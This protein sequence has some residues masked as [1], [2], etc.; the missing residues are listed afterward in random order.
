MLNEYSN[1]IVTCIH[2]LDD[3]GFWQK[4]VI[5]LDCDIDGWGFDYANKVMKDKSIKKMHASCRRVLSWRNSMTGK[6]HSPTTL[7]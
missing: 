5:F 3:E 6:K 2:C 4:R 1:Q 7:M